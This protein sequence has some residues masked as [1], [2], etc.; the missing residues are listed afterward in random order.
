[1]E[2]MGVITRQVEPTDWVNSMVTV[3]K[4]KKI[5]ICMDPQDLNEAIKKSITH[6]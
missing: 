4:L 2:Q 5:R 1:M 3:V 6:Y